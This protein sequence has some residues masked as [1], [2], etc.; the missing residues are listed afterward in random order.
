MG[1]D[2]SRWPSGRNPILFE[3]DLRNSRGPIS[4]ED[5]QTVLTTVREKWGLSPSSADDF[6]FEVNKA[7]NGYLALL[8]LE[9]EPAP[10]ELRDHFKEILKRLEALEG[11]LWI[12]EPTRKR[13]YIDRDAKQK[14]TQKPKAE[15]RKLMP[16]PIE[17]ALNVSANT[18][19]EQEA[20]EKDGGK[21]DR[22]SVGLPP[23]AYRHAF[24]L[25]FP[26][27]DVE[28]TTT[29]PEEKM[30]TNWRGER[31]VELVLGPGGSLSSA[32]AW[33]VN[34]IEELEKEKGKRQAQDAL[35][36][37]TESLWHIWVK[38]LGGPPVRGPGAEGYSDRP[39]IEF[40]RLIQ[41]GFDI[42]EPKLSASSIRGRLQKIPDQ[43]FRQK[44]AAAD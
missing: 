38:D 18:V 41:Q 4:R 23:R 8:D 27:D 12:D 6:F 30:L 25:E 35:D 43:R 20:K 22:T 16:R 13:F 40:V 37:F 21:L 42:D 10:A 32:K 17:R 29:Y 2:I 31:A 33:V 39:V 24:H 44:T 3:E 36:A 9:L 34:A 15:P 11:L 28:P 7:A 14:P 19:A 26:G 5:V 1:K